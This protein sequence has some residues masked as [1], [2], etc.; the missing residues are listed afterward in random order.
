MAFLIPENIP[1]RSDL[2]DRLQ[3]VARAFRDHAGDEVTVWLETV[4][5][6]AHLLVLDPMIGVFLIGV[7]TVVGGR[8]RS[9]SDSGRDQARRRPRFRRR[10]ERV[11]TILSREVSTMR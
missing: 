5:G 7:P 4:E 9:D 1:S 2:P 11:S 6:Q 3:E 10:C 8:M